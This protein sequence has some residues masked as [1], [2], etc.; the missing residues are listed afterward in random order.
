MAELLSGK[1]ALVTGSASGIGRATA[2]AC[3]REGAKT[4]VSDVDVAGGGQTVGMIESA[5]GE[6]I[7]VRADVTADD[8][9][10]AL[11]QMTVAAYGQLDCAFNNA[12]IEC[13][14]THPEQRFTEETFHAT[15]DTNLKG[16]WLCM[17]YEIQQM[18]DQG[19]GAIVNSSSIAGLVGIA[20]QPIYVASKHAVAGITKSA[21][22]EYA[23]QGIRINAVA[24]GLVDTPIMDRIYA[25]NPELRAEADDWQPIGRTARPEE[26]AE[27]VVWLCSDK[28][29]FVVGHV[30]VVDGGF[31]AR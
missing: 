20:R 11:V 15:V 4:V 28:A 19:F 29:S 2:L 14:Y 26:I 10:A 5:G 22:V 30:M 1:V 9:V 7:F 23:D 3:A 21:A 13:E 17:K 24:P 8:E 18:L 31:V 6:A 12:G 16:V 25:S 27:A